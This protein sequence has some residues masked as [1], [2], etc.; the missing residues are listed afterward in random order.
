[1]WR[2]GRIAIYAICLLV[3]QIR[4]SNSRTSWKL[5]ADGI[6]KSTQFSTSNDD[7]PIFDILANT[8]NF[9]NGPGWSKT[10]EGQDKY[11]VF[12]NEYGNI[13]AGTPDRFVYLFF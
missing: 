8:V 5:N 2:D 9:N 11:H 12:C 4:L 7:D 1:M 6:V 10:A 3:F 13:I